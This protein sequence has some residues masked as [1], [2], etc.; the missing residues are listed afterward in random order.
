MHR[1][2][3]LLYLL[4][5]ISLLFLTG[6]VSLVEEITVLDDGS[7][8]LRFALG[9][10]TE[11]YEPFKE[12]IPEGFDLENLFAPLARDE[13]VTSI[14]FD[15]YEADGL[16]WESVELAV[17]DFTVTFNQ[18]RRIG[19]VTIELTEQ[20]GEYSFTQ[21]ID[22]ENSTLIIPGI[23]LLD[24]ADSSFTVSLSTP[25]IVWTNGVQTSAGV[26]TWSIPLG[27]VF[28]DG[29]TAFLQAGYVLEPFEGVFIPWEVFFPYVVIGFLA[30]GGISILVVILVNTTGNREKEPKLK[31]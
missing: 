18:P 29:S 3:F 2:K 1:R 15:R 12:G 14:D 9:V 13:S 16:V 27:E 23:N 4:T 30:L 17:E 6:C 20:G 7:G 19:P 8:T 11:A 5:G 24:M 22:V 31:F 21:T 26:S 28:Q 25:Q 10:A